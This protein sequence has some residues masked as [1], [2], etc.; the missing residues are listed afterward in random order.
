M[1]CNI[2]EQAPV[3]FEGPTE[4]QHLLEAHLK[5]DVVKAY[6]GYLKTEP[7]LFNALNTYF[8]EPDKHQNVTPLFIYNEEKNEL[9]TLMANNKQLPD[10]TGEPGSILAHVR[11]K[12]YNDA[13]MCSDCYGQLSCSSCA[14]EVLGGTL[15]NPTPREEEFDMLD[16]DEGKPPTEKTRLGCQAIIGTTPLVISIRAPEKK[17]ISKI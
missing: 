17:V 2:T 5:E 6:A 12:G 15:E 11:D 4:L 13:F 16:I 3:N 1:I 14:V 10:E 8:S 9:V 7:K